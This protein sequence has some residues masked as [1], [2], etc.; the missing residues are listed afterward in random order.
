MVQSYPLVIYFGKGNNF[1]LLPFVDKVELLLSG[2]V[3]DSKLSPKGDN[4]KL[5]PSPFYY[6]SSPA[7]LPYSSLPP[8]LSPFPFTPLFPSCIRSFTGK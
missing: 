1:T 8:L 5:L 6:S 7:C 3:N 4:V 2:E